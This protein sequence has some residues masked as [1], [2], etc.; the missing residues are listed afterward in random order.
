M[1]E[2]SRKVSY[3]GVYLFL[4]QFL[5]RDVI[6]TS[7]YTQV[8]YVTVTI[9]IVTL[10]QIFNGTESDE[11]PICALNPVQQVSGVDK[12]DGFGEHISY[13]FGRGRHIV[14]SVSLCSLAYLRNH[15][16]ELY[17][18]LSV[19]NVYSRSSV[20]SSGFMYFPFCRWHH[21]FL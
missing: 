15:T 18:I 5:A 11:M 3:A 8:Y 16:S 9:C 13:S 20:Y 2:R 6:Y 4:A 10:L 14:M 17:H 12:W 21:V 1:R 19:H 7:Q